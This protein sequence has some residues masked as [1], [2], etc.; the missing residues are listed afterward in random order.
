M[1]RD[2]VGKMGSRVHSGFKIQ[3]YYFGFILPY[4]LI[5][6]AQRS[7]AVHPLGYLPT[8]VLVEHSTKKE[9]GGEGV[10]GVEK[11]ESRELLCIIPYY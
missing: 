9:G 8:L 5:E 3:A 10:E 7:R 6:I 1:Y 4:I 11:K 2:L